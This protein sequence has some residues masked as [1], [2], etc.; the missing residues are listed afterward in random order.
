MNPVVEE[1]YR[2]VTTLERAVFGRPAP[3]PKSPHDFV[4]DWRPCPLTGCTRSSYKAL[5]ACR[6]CRGWDP[7]L[8]DYEPSAPRETDN[9]YPKGE[10]S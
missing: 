8:G 6:S 4:S 2:R 3:R 10:K 1:L 5:P 9:S 7:R